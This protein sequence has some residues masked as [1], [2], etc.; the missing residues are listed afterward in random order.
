MT[1]PTAEW[2]AAAQAR[3][4]DVL[5][6]PNPSQQQPPGTDKV[7][8]ILGWMMWAGSITAF[9]GILIVAYQFMLS[10]N[11]HQNDGASSLGKVGLGMLLVGAASGIV[12]AV[13]G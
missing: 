9:I 1:I 12:G 6:A 8:T 13:L 4:V 3:L 2:A 10:P 7:D 11:R 5:A